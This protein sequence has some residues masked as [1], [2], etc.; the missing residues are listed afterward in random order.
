M[1]NKTLF[2]IYALSATV[3]FG[4]GAES[5]PMTPIFFFFKN[6]L[7][8]DQSRI[9]FL[10]SWVTLAWVVKPLW[11]YLSDSF[12][13]KKI[14]VII[15][16]VG[17][18]IIA[19]TLGLIPYLPIVWLL[20]LMGLVNVNSAVRDV[21][22]DGIM[23]VEGKERGITGKI[24]S[25]QWGFLTVATLITGVLGGWLSEVGTY[26]VAYLILI[27][28]YLIIIAIVTQYKPSQIVKKSKIDLLQTVKELLTDKRLLLV[29]LFL[30]LYKLS[31]AFGTPLTFIMQDDFKWSQTFIG[32]MDTIT[33]AVGLIGA[34]LYFYFSKRINLKKGLF[35][36][37]FVGALITSCYIYFTPVTA[38]VYG[39]IGGTIGMFINLLLLDFMARNTVEGKEAISFALLCSVSNLASTCNGFLGSFLFPILGLHWLIVISAIASFLC[40]PIIPYLKGEDE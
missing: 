3:Y 40:L 37:V 24:Q 28:I 38:I 15:S 10:M 19:L 26:Q 39:I 5:L 4:Q 11:G 23:C 25:I 30:F 13:T 18:L 14:W 1:K 33:S 6:S 32:L 35:I 20:I 8:L 2:W 12:L 31:P 34:G 21:N 9:M 27:P 22:V 17:S 16:L 36:S 7:H 29:C